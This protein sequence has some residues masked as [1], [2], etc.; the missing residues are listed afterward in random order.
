MGGQS[1]ELVGVKE[2]F[3][4]LKKLP[5]AVQKQAVGRSLVESAEPMADAASANAPK[6]SGR[7]ARSIVAAGSAK[8]V[9]KPGRYE[10][11]AYV[12][13]TTHVRALMDAEFGTR[14]R[15]QRTT[16]R[17]TGTEPIRPFLR[18]AFDGG[19]QDVVKNF[20]PILGVQIKL[21]FER[22]YK[23]IR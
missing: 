23:K 3:D 9:Q 5:D 2:L 12:G 22:V 7:G 20:G 10:V 19:W 8:G 18:P 16:G 14:N 11:A 21:A 6:L 17:D 15:K 1:M 13:P 4:A